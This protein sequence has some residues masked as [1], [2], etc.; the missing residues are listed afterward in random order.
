MITKIIILNK[1][2]YFYIKI[3]IFKSYYNASII[4]Q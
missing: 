4:L 1:N 3:I 2:N